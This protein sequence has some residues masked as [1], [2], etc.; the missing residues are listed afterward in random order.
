MKHI[1]FI[2][3]FLLLCAGTVLAQ[4]QKVSGVVKDPFLGETVVGANVVIKELTQEL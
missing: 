1:I 3:T 2:L 4:K